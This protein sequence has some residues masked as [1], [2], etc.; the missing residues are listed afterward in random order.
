MNKYTTFFEDIIKILA[1]LSLIL[2]ICGYVDVKTYYGY[3]GIN[4]SGYISSSEILTASLDNLKIVIISLL[5]QLFIWLSFFNYLFN[6]TVEDVNLYWQNKAKPKEYAQQLSMVRLFESKRMKIFV[7]LIILLLALSIVIKLIF[8]KSIFAIQL[9]LFMGIT[10]WIFM[11][12]YLAF[13]TVTKPMWDKLKKQKRYD[14][15]LLI[16]FIVFIPILVITIWV[17]N[18]A[19]VANNI[20][21]YGNSER[22]ELRLQNDSVISTNDSVRYLGRTENYVFFWNKNTW[23]SKIYP[24]GQVKEITNFKQK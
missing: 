15:K 4:I 5:I 22:I 24:S 23:T 12:I 21:K 20:R 17:K 11:C 16:S 19:F 18:I 1:A 14:P 8:P 3:F 7:F 9:S 2:L 13:F 10:L 6:Y